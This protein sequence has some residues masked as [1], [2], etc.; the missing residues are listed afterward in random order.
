MKKLFVIL[1][2]LSFILVAFI[3]IS[4]S[5]NGSRTIQLDEF[6]SIEPSSSIKN[7]EDCEQMASIFSIVPG[8]YTI[9]WPLEQDIPLQKLYTAQM[10]LK[11]RL[12]KQLKIKDEWIKRGYVDEFEFSLTDADGNDIYPYCMWEVG[13]AGFTKFKEH[14]VN[15]D[16]FMEFVRFLQSEPGTEM[17][18]T[19][20]DQLIVSSVADNLAAVKNAKGLKLKVKDDYSCLKYVDSFAKIVK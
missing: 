6:S 2:P 5:S 11:L 3:F 19:I 15:P 1:Y 20:G 12:N 16:L 10:V 18:I 13:Y 14:G 4:C 7:M 9:S 8:E 17:D